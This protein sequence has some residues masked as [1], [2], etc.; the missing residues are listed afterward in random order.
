M[1]V[2]AC[3]TLALALASHGMAPA[4][5]AEKNAIYYNKTG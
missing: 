3:A 1:S 5:A 4:G 2:L